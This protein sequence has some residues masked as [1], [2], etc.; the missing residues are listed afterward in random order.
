MILYVLTAGVT[1][2]SS[3]NSARLASLGGVEYSLGG[4]IFRE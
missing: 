2:E 3:V 4:S 1:A